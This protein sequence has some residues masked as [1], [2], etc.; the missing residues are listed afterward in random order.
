VKARGDIALSARRSTCAI[1][2]SMYRSLIPEALSPTHDIIRFVSLLGPVSGV[3]VRATSGI[4]IGITSPCAAV[5]VT[6]DLAEPMLSPVRI[7]MYSVD[8]RLV[9]EVEE[10]QMSAGR[11]VIDLSLADGRLAVPTGFYIVRIEG[12]G[13]DVMIRKVL[14]LR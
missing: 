2:S 4:N 12:L 10:Q 13:S 14:V 8:G 9:S 1:C 11:H 7:G 5:A 6:L 3:K